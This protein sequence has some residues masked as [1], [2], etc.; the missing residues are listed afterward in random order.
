[1]TVRTVAAHPVAV[2]DRLDPFA[3]GTLVLLC[4]CWGLN[5]VA[6]KVTNAGLQPVFQSGLRS[7]LGALLVLL[8][9]RARGVRLTVR[10]GT[11]VPGIVAGLL[12]A[13]EFTLIYAALDFTT[14]ARGIVLIYF[15]PVVVAV[16][17]HFL[18]P[19]ERLTAVRLVGLVAA[20]AGV[21]IAF[22][23]KLSLPESRAL[24]GDV[25]CLIAA[26]VWAA[27]TLV[28]KATRLNRA[29][30]EAVL[31][32][33]L[34]VSA[35]VMLVMAP[36]FG[37]LFRDVGWLVGLGLFYQVVIVVAASYVAWFWL[38]AR[39]PAGQLSAFTF[40]TP[41]FAVALG[42]LLLAEPVSPRLVL[43]LVLVAGGIFLVS[44]R[45]VA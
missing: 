29:P 27:T 19:R 1:V 36:F 23:D 10:D 28:I 41:L 12:F 7:L 4:L 21:V 38:L 20:F 5:Q 17:A 9:C 32:Y 39:Y 40:L 44:R 15:A 26:F 18:I 42:A 11:L 31:L 30:A 3:S 34:G 14:V 24:F 43:A 33:Q 25:L 16:G 35:P 2:H 37:P 6:I 13:L 8:W 22:S 45:R